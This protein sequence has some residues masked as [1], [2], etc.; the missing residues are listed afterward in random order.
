MMTE[1]DL[2]V[3]E[4][5]KYYGK[6]VTDQIGTLSHMPLFFD[7][8][9]NFKPWEGEITSEQVDTYRSLVKHWRD[10]IKIIKSVRGT[11]SDNSV[12]L[13]RL[14]ALFKIT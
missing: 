1:A 4:L 11:L 9:T 6:N 10:T 13:V 7:M 3:E 12:S 5:G 8:I 14:L 2:P